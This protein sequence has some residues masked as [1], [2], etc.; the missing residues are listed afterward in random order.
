MCLSSYLFQFRETNEWTGWTNLYRFQLARSGSYHLKVK[1]LHEKY[2]PVVRLGPDL[3]DL[4]YP[5][6]IKTMYGTDNKWVKVRASALLT[7]MQ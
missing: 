1:A 6:L 2:G 7:A 3:L 5:E 4:D